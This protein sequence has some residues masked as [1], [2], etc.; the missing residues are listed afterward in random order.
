MKEKEKKEELKCGSLPTADI[1]GA[2]GKMRSKRIKNYDL[3]NKDEPTACTHST[4]HPLCGIS[5]ISVLFWLCMARICC[6]FLNQ[7]MWPVY[8]EHPIS[9]QK[10]K[11]QY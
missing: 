2:V 1:V 9:K 8:I 11:M 3:K 10:Y 6:K 5:K 7:G 4:P